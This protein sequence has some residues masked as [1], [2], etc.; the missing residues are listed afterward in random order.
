MSFL[1]YHL[2]FYRRELQALEDTPP[3]AAHIYRARQLLKM[4]DD[5]ADEAIW[6]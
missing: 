1:F 4:L 3:T 5:L 2:S 6:S